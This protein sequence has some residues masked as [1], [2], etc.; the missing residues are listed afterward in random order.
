MTAG[1]F[2]L[3]HS[4]DVKVYRNLDNLPRAYLAGAVVT[5]ST[6]DEAM[7][8]LQ[9]SAGRV[10]AVEGLDSNV[11]HRDPAQDRVEIIGVCRR[12]DCGAHGNRR[13]GLAGAERQPTIPAGR[14]RST[15]VPAPIHAV[16]VLF[17]GVVVPAGAHEVT[18][19]FVPTGWST[20]LWLAALGGLLVV[21][22]GAT[23]LILS[24]Q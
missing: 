24:R 2:E 15:S 23:S 12:G 16:N 18:F 17:R 21:M 3:V 22:A 1:A 20:G 13:L 10:T 19:T 8:V 4:G 7:A 14:P 5:A 11:G 6:L 9:S